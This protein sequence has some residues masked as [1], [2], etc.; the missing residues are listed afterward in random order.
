MK[1]FNLKKDNGFMKHRWLIGIVAILM[2][3]TGFNAQAQRVEKYA[4]EFMAIDVSARAQALGGAFSALSNDVYAAFYNPAGLVQVRSTQLGFTHTQQFL[5]SVN[6][7]YIGFARPLS[8]SKTLG[9]SLVRLGVDNI[10]DSRSAAILDANGVLQGIDE[11][12]V[13]NFNSADYVFYLSMGHQFNSAFSIGFN[14]KL[15]RRSLADFSANGLGFDAGLLYAVSDRWKI[16]GAVRNITTTLIA[17]DTGTKE[18]VSPTLRMG[19]SYL[20]PLPGLNSYFIP[21]FDVIVQSQNTPNLS[22][23]GLDGGI[24]GG[25]IGGEFAIQERLFLRGGY[26]ELQRLNLGIGIRIPHIGIDYA[27]TNYDQ[28]LGNAHRIGLL[29]DFE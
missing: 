14:V 6:Y 28:E 17:W 25:A 7:D 24:F 26:D 22:E 9:I 29:I 27:F 20:I 12:R 11:S 8:S 5:A 13:N 1:L 4:G 16:A 18:L 15:I 10:K 19:S 21:N 3:G 23:N 2:L